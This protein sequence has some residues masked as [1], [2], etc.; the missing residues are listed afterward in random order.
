MSALLIFLLKTKNIITL[1]PRYEK[2]FTAL[3]Y[4]IIKTQNDFMSQMPAVVLLIT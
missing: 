4:F 1:Q 3:K 2:Y